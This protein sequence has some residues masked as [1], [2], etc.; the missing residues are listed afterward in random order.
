MQSEK[1]EGLPLAFAHYDSIK[2]IPIE[3]IVSEINEGVSKQGAPIQIPFPIYN[4][5]DTLKYWIVNNEP[6]R[7]SVNL[8]YPNKAVWPTFF[9]KD[10]ELVFVRHRMWI[11][12]HPAYARERMIYLDGGKIV[13]CEERS[14][15]LNQGDVPAYIREI[16]F[17]ICLDPEKEIKEDYER[18]WKSVQE[19]MSK[20][21]K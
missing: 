4:A 14:M 18:Y 1:N 21:K 12:E 11:Q 5:A 17:S 10:N 6:A 7:I 15:D 16:P 20:N 9:V 3:T 8:I 13:Y 2:A 19:F